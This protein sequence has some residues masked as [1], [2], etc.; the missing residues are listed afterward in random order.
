M[1]AKQDTT[2]K[3][4]LMQVVLLAG[5]ILTAFKFFA[6][7]LTHSNAILTDALESIINIVAAAFGL[8]SL[9]YAGRPKDDNHPYGHGKVEF[10]AVGFEGA[11]IFIAGCGMIIKAA[12][13]FRKPAEIHSL[14]TGVVLVAFTAL[15][16]FGIGKHLIAKGKKMHSGTLIADGQHL[17]ADT[18]SSFVLMAGLALIMITGEN[19][20]DLILTIGLGIYILIVGY[21]LLRNSAAGLMDEMDMDLVG[22]VVEVLKKER[23]PTWIDIHNLR[24][25]KHGSYLHIDAHLTLPFYETL[26]NS[27][28]E[29]KNLERK[30]GEHFGDRV[31]FFIHTDPCHFSACGICY[32]ENCQFRKEEHQTAVSWSTDLL[33][34]NKPHH[35]SNELNRLKQVNVEN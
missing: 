20:I 4:R 2:H 1:S 25:V 19:K 24:V 6:W 23:K 9:T 8:F 12:L 14:D 3:I 15:I 16:N 34:T 11:L 32:V 17:I 28:S 26:E 5:I 31:E 22:E 10:F 27:H 21:R 7:S 30:V 35:H 18:Y 29:V 13:A 33:M